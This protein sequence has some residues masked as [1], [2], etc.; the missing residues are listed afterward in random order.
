MVEGE[1]SVME[2]IDNRTPFEPTLNDKIA[3]SIK[4]F[5][6]RTLARNISLTYIILFNIFILAGDAFGFP[7]Y[8]ILIFASCATFAC[9][10]SFFTF[11]VPR[12]LIHFRDGK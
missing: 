6:N 12:L 1:S 8:M 4:V 5:S 3:L 7:L 9:S 10:Y 2:Q 11:A